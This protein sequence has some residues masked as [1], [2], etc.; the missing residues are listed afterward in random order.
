M[1]NVVFPELSEN[2]YSFPWKY[3]Y[4]FLSLSVA[5]VLLNV[6]VPV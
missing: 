3:T 1:F 6:I 5:F 4:S 2:A